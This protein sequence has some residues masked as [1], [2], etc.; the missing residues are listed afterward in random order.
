M[1]LRV[2]MAAMLMASIVFVSTNVMSNRTGR[3]NAS[4]AP[5]D[6]PQNCAN[7]GCHVSFG[8]APLNENILVEINGTELTPAFEYDPNSDYV[9]K[10]TVQ[11]ANT[12]R[13]GFS[14]KVYNEND[15][16]AGIFT[17]PN[18]NDVNLSNN[19]TNL[20]HNSN[21]DST[22]TFQWSPQGTT[23]PVT[24]YAS[25]CES[26]NQNSPAG[27]TIR[28]YRLTINDNVGINR[29][30]AEAL[31]VT[32][33]GNPLITN[34]IGLAINA[35]QA[36]LY[37]FSLLNMLGNQINTP[38]LEFLHKG[39]HQLQLPINQLAPGIYILTITANQQMASTKI[40][41]Q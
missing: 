30:T 14:F 38:H 27:D 9:V 18:D 20:T 32:I 6:T 39:Q 10:L 28:P 34:Q 40:V 41:V 29:V 33:K 37:K 35:S 11:E 8:L 13:N 4:G 21:A 25:I 16:P 3:F 26:N 15:T 5:G 22:W 19:N 12:I 17:V 7:A 36:K 23:G 31:G 24:F 2:L 1:K